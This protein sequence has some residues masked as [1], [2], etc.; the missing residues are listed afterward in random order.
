M[1]PA[2][3]CRQRKVQAGGVRRRSVPGWHRGGE[4]AGW[5]LPSVTL[6]LLPK[7]PACVAGYVA[8]GTGI[9]ISLPTA[10]YLRVA[11]VVLCVASL[12]FIAVR[13]LWMW[14][15]RGQGER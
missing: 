10:T 2:P 12:L 3:C 4:L 15:V 7:C 8:L 11:L 1:S 14:L 13:R 5:V 6:A 9:G